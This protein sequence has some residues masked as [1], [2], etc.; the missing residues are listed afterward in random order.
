MSS[1]ETISN[2]NSSSIIKET[3]KN[4]MSRFVVSW[5]HHQIETFSAFL[6][7]CAGNSPACDRWV[8]NEAGDLR[9]YR[10]HYD[11]TVIGFVAA[12]CQALFSAKTSATSVITVFASWALVLNQPPAYSCISSVKVTYLIPAFINIYIV[13]S[14]VELKCDFVYF[15]TNKYY[16]Y[17]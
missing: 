16:F 15:L 5:W 1:L 4:V 7:I 6:A 13:S 17:L 8:K 14:S 12:D 11:V 10:A 9:R 3:L 2:S